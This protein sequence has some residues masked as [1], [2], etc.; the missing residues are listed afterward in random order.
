MS[1]LVQSCLDANGGHFQ[2]M[3][4]CRHIS[5]TT[6]VLLFK[7][8]C[9][10]FIGVRIIKER[11]VSVASGTS[12]RYK[13]KSLSKQTT[14]YRRLECKH[15]RRNSSSDNGRT[16]KKFLKYGAPRS[17]L[18]GRNWWP[19]PAHVMMSSHFSHNE[20]TPVQILL[21]CSVRIIKEMPFSV[22]SGT[23]CRYKA[24]LSLY[25]RSWWWCGDVSSQ[26]P[27]SRAISPPVDAQVGD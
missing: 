4:W 5:H 17:I 16:G 18:S 2:H 15:R 20:S 24:R 21:Q 6:N 9:N 10:I 27:F 26:A 11:L 19:L 25:W 12:C 1:H 23:P 3:L 22:A 13:A 7:C 14:N 8:C